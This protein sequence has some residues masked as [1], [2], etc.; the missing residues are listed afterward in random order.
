MNCPICNEP[1]NCAMEVD[2]TAAD[3]WCFQTYFPKEL[4]QAVPPEL[5]DKACICRK[6]VE[7]MALDTN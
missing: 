7:R 5:K 2:K 6:C 3:C 4:L 1:N